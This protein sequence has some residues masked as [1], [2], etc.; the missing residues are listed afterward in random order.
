MRDEE[1]NSLW[2]HLLGKCTSGELIGQS[3]PTLPSLLTDWESWKTLHPDT[4]VMMMTRT[5]VDFT[6][7]KYKN[8]ERF[9]VGL[10]DGQSSKAW[11]FTHL[12][13][14]P[15]I[16]DEFAGQ[17]VVLFF[18]R[19]NGT[20]YIFASR[21]GETSLKFT[22]AEGKIV[23]TQTNSTWD[24]RSG[25]ALHGKLKGVQLK[26]HVGITSF[27]KSWHAFYPESQ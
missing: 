4:T 12:S 24:L 18:D 5:R 21:H 7:N 23:D 22:L 27:A 10:T 3:L 26:Q 9:V 20:P 17:P 1:T 2:S 16:N 19:D 11:N 15:L 6:T 8:L 25:T 13:E 14:N